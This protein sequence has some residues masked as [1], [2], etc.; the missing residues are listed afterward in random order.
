MLHAE[1]AREAILNQAAL[2]AAAVAVA[3]ERFADFA[4]CYDA[5]QDLAPGQLAALAVV[6]GFERKWS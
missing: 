5:R 4:T 3:P 2:L 1:V 6:K